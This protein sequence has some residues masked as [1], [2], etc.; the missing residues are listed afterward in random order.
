MGG[1][2]D[3]S[4]TRDR[5]PQVTVAVGIAM[6]GS[7]FVVLAAWDRITGL[8][9]LDT[10]ESL[11]SVLDAPVLRDNDLTVSQLVVAV[12][13]VSMVAAACATAI[14]VL[15]VQTLRRSRTAR[16]LMTVLAVP[17]FLGG[18]AAD[19][20]FSS[21]VAAAVATLWFGPA[22]TWFLDAARARDRTPAIWP[23]PRQMAGHARPPE[24][25]V[26]QGDRPP[27]GTR[28]HPPA[29]SRAWA[30]PTS[31]TY[32]VRRGVAGRP[33]ALLT[34]C[35][36]TWMFC[37]MTVLLV[38]A[39]LIVLAIDS[40]AVLDQMHRQDPRLSERGITDHH[41][42]LFAY[43]TGG[44]V[45][46][47]AVAAAVVAALVFKRRRWAWSALL[48]STTAVVVLGLVAVVGF[49]LVLVPL[50]AAVVTLLLLTR[51]EVR[52]WVRP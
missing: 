22:R 18:L 44:I 14:A 27:A 36:L 34:A 11:R 19:G 37:S 13:V 40:T 20:I 45:I 7:I 50:T 48:V 33:N 21:A 10:R 6:L 2:S 16:L 43:V 49:V 47:W 28:P 8:H 52:Q 51:R 25:G 26:P 5:P 39:S 23:P 4:V 30:P 32:D 42:L 29:S 38:G 46:A 31:S 17:M 9:S 3:P 35:L 41:L 1:V 24:R 12:R 15:S